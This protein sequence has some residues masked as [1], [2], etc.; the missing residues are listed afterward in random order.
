MTATAHGPVPGSDSPRRPGARP[1]PVAPPAP[2]VRN[3]RRPALLALGV[4]LVATG[5]LAA[6]WLVARAGDRVGVVVLARDVPYG[7]TLT[8]GDLSVT[9]VS[10]D[11][12]VATVPAAQLSELVGQVAAMPLSRGTLVSPTS[13]QAAAPPEAG[14]VLVAVA[15]PATRMPVGRLAAGDRVQVVSTPPR[16][17]EVSTEQPATIAA[18]VVRLGDPDLDGITVVDLSAAPDDGTRLAA[19][20]AT[21]RVALVLQPPGR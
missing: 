6:G 18:T 9:E 4:A 8:P 15:L 7:A 13:V 11:P 16:D 10:V 1:M 3:R 2:V 19:W 5:A 12:A 20:S 14:Q 21:G 17:G